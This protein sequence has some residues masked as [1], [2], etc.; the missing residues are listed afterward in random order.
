MRIVKKEQRL[1]SNIEDIYNFLTREGQLI[2]N[3]R[4]RHIGIDINSFNFDVID[5]IRKSVP[6]FNY[7]NLVFPFNLRKK[8]YLFLAY[9]YDVNRIIIESKLDLDFYKDTMVYID[10]Q[11]CLDS[12]Y[13][14]VY[15]KQHP[16]KR[17]SLFHADGYKKEI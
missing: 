15:N 10:S 4:Y 17:I 7:I 8:N 6:R 12:R 9:Q 11:A 1:I 2:I 14:I 16:N 13:E 5:Y 3:D